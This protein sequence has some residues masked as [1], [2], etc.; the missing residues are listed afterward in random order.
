MMPARRQFNDAFQL[1]LRGT[2]PSSFTDPEA[3][4]SFPQP[5]HNSLSPVG[6]HHLQRKI[7]NAAAASLHSRGLQSPTMASTPQENACE[8]W[9]CEHLACMWDL[10]NCLLFVKYVA[11]WQTKKLQTVRKVCFCHAR[12]WFGSLKFHWVS[13]DF[14]LLHLLS[15][16]MSAVWFS[17][18]IILLYAPPPCIVGWLPRQW[19]LVGW[20]PGQWTLDRAKDHLQYC[21]NNL[22]G[23]GVTAI[24][25]SESRGRCR[26]W[27]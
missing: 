11:K 6:T 8:G 16:M 26:H 19:A 22:A 13:L 7:S 4:A 27:P 24:L 3:A 18:P 17:F 14:E 21:I 20:L 23:E 1:H 25:K 15:I 10:M 2:E 9:Q 12:V 5:T